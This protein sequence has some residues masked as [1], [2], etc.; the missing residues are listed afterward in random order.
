MQ[1]VY[2]KYQGQAAMVGVSMGPR[3]TLEAV[4]SFVDLYKYS[5]IFLQDNDSA[6]AMAYQAYSIPISYFIDKDGVIR[7][8]HIGAM[9]QAV[10][11][12]YLQKAQ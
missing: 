8:V 7:A 11:E 2:N 9:T 6:V 12:G 1:K 10:M 4:K 3:D 5:W